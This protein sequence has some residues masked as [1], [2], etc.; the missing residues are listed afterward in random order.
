ME[1]IEILYQ[2]PTWRNSVKTHKVHV[3]E[4]D[5]YEAYMCEYHPQ[6]PRHIV[7]TVE[8]FQP[9]LTWTTCPSFAT[10]SMAFQYDFKYFAIFE[11]FEETLSTLSL[12][13]V[14]HSYR[15]SVKGLKYIHQK[16]SYHG[17]ICTENIKTT[18][19]GI[20]IIGWTLPKMRS[21]DPPPTP[22]N[23]F[24]SEIRA[25]QASLAEISGFTVEEI[26]AQEQEEEAGLGY[27]EKKEAVESKGQV[28]NEKQVFFVEGKKLMTA[29]LEGK[30]SLVCETR[31]PKGAC[32]S[33][34]KGMLLLSGGDD[35]DLELKEFKF[36]EKSWDDKST[37]RTKHKYHSCI[38]FQEKLWIVGGIRS[39]K[40]ESFDGTQWE[41]CPDL[42]EN[43]ENPSCSVHDTLYVYSKGIYK[44][45]I[46]EWV[47][48]FVWDSISF[49]GVNL[50]NTDILILGGRAN[51]KYS[52]H[53]LIYSQT[54]NSISVISEGPAGL[55][56][57]FSYFIHNGSLII[58]NNAGKLKTF[59][60]DSFKLTP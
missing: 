3:T 6:N 5:S 58:P 36:E 7:D 21:F 59:H 47:R 60:L 1:F 30:A 15:E 10:L 35:S 12:E 4:P 52:Y 49:Q 26:V 37:L 39:N 44:L 53:N 24:D 13:Q 22:E 9:L 2:V 46:N 16:K 19:N 25:L 48:V 42:A 28:F 32:L 27:T 40:C 11:Y 54:T 8:K 34:Y 41:I 14:Q 43:V 31:V 17:D 33:W 18:A 23:E 38:E 29:D 56:G 51:H 57:L 45:T 55:Y 50:N 20:K